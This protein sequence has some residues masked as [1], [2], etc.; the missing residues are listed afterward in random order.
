MRRPRRKKSVENFVFSVKISKKK[1]LSPEFI[2][3]WNHVDQNQCRLL[4]TLNYWVIF[5]S[6]RSKEHRRYF[7]S[8][9]FVLRYIMIFCPSLYSEISL[10]A[11][12]WRKKTSISPPALGAVKNI[13]TIALQPHVRLKSVSYWTDRLE[14][15]N[16]YSKVMTC[17]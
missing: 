8:W 14:S 6:Q 16:N 3:Y 10:P 2:S 9:N 12:M 4:E 5:F 11:T 15:F 1:K 13:N 17:E 7:W